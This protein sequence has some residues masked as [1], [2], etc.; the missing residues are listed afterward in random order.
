[1]ARRLLFVT[2]AC[3]LSP[4]CFAQST[5]PGIVLDP[6]RWTLTQDIALVS[7]LPVGRQM[8]EDKITADLY[9]PKRDGKLPAA[10]IVNSSGGV[11]PH[12]EL[13]YGRLLASQGVAALVVDSFTPRGVR[14]TTDDQSRVWQSQSD[15]DAAAGY[16]WLAGQPWVDAARII[17]LGMSRGGSAALSAALGSPRQRLKMTDT[18]FAAHVAIATGGCNIQA[19]DARTTGAPIFLMLAELDNYTPIRACL[20]Y[21]ERMRDAGNQNVRL[22]VY[23]GVYHAYEWTG[24]LDEEIVERWGRC[25]NYQF[26][27]DG[28]WVDRTSGKDVPAGQERAVALKTCVDSGPVTI[29]GEHRVKMQAIADLLQFLRDAGI[30]VDAD[31]VAIVPDCGAVPDGI[32]RRNC[33]RAR[34]GWIGDMVALARAFRAG[35]IKRDPELAARLFRL[36]A[37]RGHPQAK[38]E[39]AEMQVQGL[40]VAKDVSAARVLLRDAMAAGEAPA[41]NI[42]GYMA[43]DGIG[44]P[45]DDAE[46]VRLFKQAAELRHSWGLANLGRMYWQGRGGLAT[47]RTEAVRLWRK[48]VAYDNP[49]GQFYLAEALET[50]EGTERNTKEALEYYGRAAAQERDGNISRRAAEAIKR[51]SAGATPAAK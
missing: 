4:P 7:R 14:K 1:M 49:V 39:F 27:A 35:K 37:E 13:F 8:R 19:A 11:S 42:L 17:V 50:G 41:M 38:W 18:H 9:R 3:L 32:L 16:R 15:A 51:M 34:A 2:L 6:E 10:V 48:S 47:D 29:G 21:V 22:A 12:T 30:I 46:A 33:T 44:A 25:T 26:L 23:P 28:R 24:G 43:R 45:R 5:A 20:R 40:G 36:A 31:A